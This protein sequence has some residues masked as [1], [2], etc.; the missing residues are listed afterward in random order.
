MSE[1]VPHFYGVPKKDERLEWAHR[2]IV[3]ALALLAQ[4]SAGATSRS[5]SDA[6]PKRNFSA[7]SSDTGKCTAKVPGRNRRCS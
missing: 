5:S 7:A 4:K 1:D 2:T 3:A 6:S